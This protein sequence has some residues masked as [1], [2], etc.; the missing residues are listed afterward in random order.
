MVGS[1]VFFTGEGSSDADMVGQITPIHWMWD[2]DHQR[3]G[4]VGCI[5]P[6]EVPAGADAA[7]ADDDM[8]ADHDIDKT[9]TDIEKEADAVRTQHVYDEAGIYLVTLNVWDDNHLFNFH[10]TMPTARFVHIQSDSHKSDDPALA[11]ADLTAG[12]NAD[13]TLN[14]IPAVARAVKIR[15][16]DPGLRDLTLLVNGQT[17]DVANLR[18]QQVF[19][20]D[21]AIAMASDN[22]NQVR[23]IAG[24]SSVGQATIEVVTNTKP[25][26]ASTVMVAP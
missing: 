8:D 14:S 9:R 7:T 2:F 24:S 12:H 22:Q 1:T 6:Y 15:N 13:I 19:V 5:A 20:V 11:T 3:K 18:P 4:C 25:K 21:I 17:F 10:N 16:G 23:L 26:V